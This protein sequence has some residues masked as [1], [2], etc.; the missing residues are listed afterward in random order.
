MAGCWRPIGTN[1]E[2]K[3]GTFIATIGRMA[4]DTFVIITDSRGRGLQSVLDAKNST[5]MRLS[6]RFYPGAGIARLTT[7]AAAHLSGAPDDVII[8]MGGVNDITTKDHRTRRVHLTKT[9][10]DVLT[11]HL[12]G[13]VDESEATLTARFPSA[14]VIY[15]PIIGLSLPVYLYDNDHGHQNAVNEAVLNFNRH[16]IGINRRRTKPTPWTAAVVHK[17]RH[18]KVEHHYG[19]LVDGL[20]PGHY[21]LDHWAKAILKLVQGLK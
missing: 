2:P 14:T 5:G 12:T 1:I 11:Q 19:Y 8:F 16:V 7:E 3:V 21:V 6:V 9:N 17:N 20:H 15:A 4:G 13:L 18:K 10:V